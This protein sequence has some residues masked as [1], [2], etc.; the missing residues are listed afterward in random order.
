MLKNS[1]NERIRVLIA[2]DEPVSRRLLE[3]LL[4]KWGYEV[5]VTHDGNQA[6]EML[7]KIGSANLVVILD[8]MM[9]GIKGIELCQRIRRRERPEYIYII[10][11]TGK[12]SKKDVITG[13]KAGADDY[14]IKPFDKEELKCR[15]NIGR[16]IIELERRI[17]ELASTDFLTKVLNRRAFI[18]RMEEEIQRARRKEAPLSLV[19]ADIDYFKKINDSYGHQAG[20]IV[21]QRFAKQLSSSLR[22]YDLVGRYGGEEFV[23]CLPGT[24]SL[25]ARSVAERIRKKV[26]KMRIE[27]P[28]SSHLIQVTASFGV[29]SLSMASEPIIDSLTNL[30]DEAMYQAKLRGRNRVCAAEKSELNKN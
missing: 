5:I 21:L 23:I 1:G 18:N 3:L 4:K 13:L 22:K 29:A 16:R 26:E 17:L 19:M 11:L 8:W 20:D 24:D 27:L 9:P 6:W 10:L 2:E 15:V 7:Q 14:V 12:G 28:D 25:P 30:A